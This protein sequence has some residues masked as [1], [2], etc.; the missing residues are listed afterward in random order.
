MSHK[1]VNWALEQRHLKPGPWIVLIQLADRHNKDT[2]RVSPYQST[3]AADCNMPRSSVNNHLDTLEA[4]GLIKRVRRIDPATKRQLGTFYILGFDFENPPDIDNAMSK[5]RTRE[6]A[7]QSENINQSRVQNPDAG[8]V[9]K[10][11]QKPCPKNAD[12]RV[13]ILDTKGT[14]EM[15]QEKEPG[16][17]G[18]ARASEKLVAVDRGSDPP[19][20]REQALI[21]M[22]HDPG[23]VTANG[24]IVGNTSDMLEVDRWK[25]DLGLSNAEI[26]HVIRDVRGRSTAPPPSTFRYFRNAMQR[27]AGE[28]AEPPL[29]KS[30][31][32]NNGV[33]H[34]KPNKSAARMRAFIAGAR[35]TS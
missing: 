21:A 19:T 25:G 18:K 8:A 5:I 20:F 1:A 26:L 11:P 2:G 13:R 27:L 12:S 29:E 7:G 28:K 9:S 15:N 35:G 4:L 23:G 3:L 24:R 30:D 16:G 34:G 17:G 32:R 6:I 22:G 33:H 31:T 10:K 14:M